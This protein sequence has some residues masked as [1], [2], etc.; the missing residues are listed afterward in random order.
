MLTPTTGPR[1]DWHLMFVLPNLKLDYAD[2]DILSTGLTLGLDELAVVAGNDGRVQEIRRW[3]PVAD[4]L[5]DSFCSSM[6]S[7]IAPAVLIGRSDYLQNL[8][9]DPEPIVNFRNAV[10]LTHVLPSRTHGGFGGRGTPWA[11][12]FNFY[13]G[14]IPLHGGSLNITTPAERHWMV[15]IH[16]LQVTAGPAVTRSF[17][18]EVDVDLATRLGAQWRS[19]HVRRKKVRVA[20]RVFRSMETAYNA[21]STHFKHYGSIYEAGHAAVMWVSALETLA[22]GL[23]HNRN[24]NRGDVLNLLDRY[25]WESKLLRVRKYRI[26]KGKK[27]PAVFSSL[28]FIQWAYVHLYTARNKFIHG[29]RI[30]ERLLYPF[31]DQVD[32]PVVSLGSTIYRTALCSLIPAVRGRRSDWAASWMN[33]YRSHLLYE[34]HLRRAV[35]GEQVDE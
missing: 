35:L 22:S 14:T 29:D 28:N 16:K 11:D 26:R 15:P 17:P 24:V 3:S 33:R 30:S 7:R 9:D 8:G 5:L 4:R 23:A 20:R 10:A 13:P 2:S 6:G 25:E 31:A 12:I 27:S 32:L 19:L 18:Y 34:E 1:P 21:S